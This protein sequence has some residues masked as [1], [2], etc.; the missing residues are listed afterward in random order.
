MSVTSTPS[1]T[2]SEVVQYLGKG[3]VVVTNA[4]G[5]IG[6]FGATPVAKPTLATNDAAGIIAALVELGLVTAA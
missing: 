4:D 1:V 3:A 5:K 2:L 6:F